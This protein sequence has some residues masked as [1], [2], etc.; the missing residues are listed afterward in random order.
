MGLWNRLF[1]WGTEEYF[2]RRVRKS[3]LVPLERLGRDGIRR[4]VLVSNTAIGDTLLS[5]PALRAVKKSFPHWTVG[6]VYHARNE[7]L[8]RYNPHVDRLHRFRGKMY[9]MRSLVHEIRDV[10]YDAAVILHGNDPESVPL[11]YA[12]GI[13]TIVGSGTSSFRFLTSDPVF[14]SAPLIHSIERRLEYV[15]RLGAADHGVQM[16]LEIPSRMAAWAE[17]W[18]RDRFGSSA[19]PVVALHPAGSRSYKWWP[20]A[21]FVE[22]SDRLREAFGAV[23]LVVCGKREAALGKAIAGATQAPAAVTGGTLDLLEV[24]A[25]LRKSTLAVSTDSGPM[26]M[27]YALGT[28]TVA[29]MG[30]HHPARFGPYGVSDAVVIYRKDLVCF[31]ERCLNRRCADN[32][33]MKAIGVEDVWN[34]IV[35]RFGG[36]IRK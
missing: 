20:V 5:T 16:D 4:I 32:V 34:V 26:H 9:S 25:L 11:C 30:P 31:E 12:A 29:L 23:I 10:G 35:N 3:P 8:V 7:A 17:S 1:S 28:P 22:L 27:A 19:G 36:L 18:I 15:R 13:R 6:L 21:R 2:L 33:C 24:G 14:P